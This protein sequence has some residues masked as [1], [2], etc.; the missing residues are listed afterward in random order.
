MRDLSRALFRLNPTFPHQYQRHLHSL[1]SKPISYKLLEEGMSEE[2]ANLFSSE[3]RDAA[4]FKRHG[5][6]R[7]IDL[8][9]SKKVV[10][11]NEPDIE[12]S[13]KDR[14]GSLQIVSKKGGLVRYGQYG[15]A[16]S[17]E[18]TP[19]DLVNKHELL[20]P[21]KSFGILTVA[22]HIPFSFDFMDPSSSVVC[23]FS[24]IEEV[25]EHEQ[26][27]KRYSI[28]KISD[29]SPDDARRLALNLEVKI[30]HD[31]KK[32]AFYEEVT[33]KVYPPTIYNRSSGTLMLFES[34]INENHT[35]SHYHPGERSLIIVTTKKPAG[36][37]LNFC[38]V[39]ENPDMRPDCR[40]KIDFP[41]NSILVLNFPPYTHH[42][43]NGDFICMSVHPREGENL[44]E[45]LRSGTLPK[46][47]LETATIFSNTGDKTLE[48]E[49]SLPKESKAQQIVQR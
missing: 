45:A 6:G 38:G 35:L 15:T 48:W 39:A 14:F 18:I 16:P 5:L 41:P 10:R 3:L 21:A 24:S 34:E 11:V 43:F 20:I 37:E 49:L 30:F 33:S 44:I 36:A 29:L 46:G 42:K 13:P 27:V 1:A 31:Y 47:F 32:E 2:K 8:S 25:V 28:S 7:S 26:N 23:S 4:N 12:I 40:T 22:K 19:F 17:K 9:E